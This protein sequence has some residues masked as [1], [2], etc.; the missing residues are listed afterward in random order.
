M[1]TVPLADGQEIGVKKKKKA[2]TEAIL[3]QEWVCLVW[4]SRFQNIFPFSSQTCIK[5]VLLSPTRS[6]SFES[7]AG[8]SWSRRS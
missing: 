6:A 3:H 2:L 1:F 7:R 8:G 4:E 5:L